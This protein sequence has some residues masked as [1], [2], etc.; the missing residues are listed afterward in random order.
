M[1]DAKYA[2]YMQTGKRIVSRYGNW[3]VPPWMIKEYGFEKVRSD[4]KKMFGDE[5]DL[6]KYIYTNEVGSVPRF[7]NYFILEKTKK[8]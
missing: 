2:E 6:R 3:A 7:S 4:L 1:N 8:G 5:Y